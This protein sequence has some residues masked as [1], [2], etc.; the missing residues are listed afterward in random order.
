[1]AAM[2]VRATAAPGERIA[3]IGAGLAGAAVAAKLADADIEVT[4]FEARD[5]VGGRAHSDLHD[6]WPLP[7]QLGGWL[8]PAAPATADGTGTANGDGE[9]SADAVGNAA[10]TTF[11]DLETVD[12]TSSLWRS[13]D[14]DTEHI[15]N[16]ALEASIAAAQS[17]P[18]DVSLTEA[19]AEIGADP[20]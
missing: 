3:V 11:A 7:V 10:A 6:D 9:D 12:L 2:R 18:A 14:Q 20:D 4:V 8:L 1:S 16:A 13:P 17:L 5:R 15:G 19:L